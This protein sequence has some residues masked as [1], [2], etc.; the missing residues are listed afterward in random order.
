MKTPR[1]DTIP[2]ILAVVLTLA[3]IGACAL[4]LYAL[5][6]VACGLAGLLTLT[7]G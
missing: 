4:F 5:Y 1:R 7:L 6:Q 2:A 3:T